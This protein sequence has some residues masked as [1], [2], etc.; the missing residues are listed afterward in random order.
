MKKILS[1]LICSQMFLS[2]LIADETSNVL[3]LMLAKDNSNTTS[4]FGLLA[5][6][7]NARLL[8]LQK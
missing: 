5:C 6:K 4:E 3:P 2:Q 8:H 7:S 1:L